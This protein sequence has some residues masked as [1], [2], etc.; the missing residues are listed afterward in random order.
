MT[1]VTSE[2]ATLYLKAWKKHC[3]IYDL[4]WE[5]SPVSIMNINCVSSAV[6]IHGPKQ[7]PQIDWTG[8]VATGMPSP[9]LLWNAPGDSSLS[10]EVINWIHFTVEEKWVLKQR[11][12][13]SIVFTSPNHANHH[14]W[15]FGRTFS[16]SQDNSNTKWK[17]LDFDDGV[18]T[19]VYKVLTENTKTEE[20]EE[21][22]K[23]KEKEK[24]EELTK[25]DAKKL[26]DVWKLDPIFVWQHT[27]V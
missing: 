5:Y 16:Y 26:I 13:N 15:K 8:N 18:R 9:F 20:K 19:R 11:N 7:P 23:D 21:K 1:S 17:I 22:E 6:L 3:E 12:T 2:L 27:C 10:V 24:K 25:I 4:V 14:V